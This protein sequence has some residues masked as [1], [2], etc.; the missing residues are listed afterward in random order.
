MIRTRTLI[1]S[2]LVLA[3][4]VALGAGC[5]P[6]PPG[7]TTPPDSGNAA[8][9]G[10]G[11]GGDGGAATGNGGGDGGDGGG[12]GGA[13]GGDGG[14]S[15]DLLAKAIA[16]ECP[17]EVDEEAPTSVFNDAVLI[18]L[19]KGVETFVEETP[20]FAYANPKNAPSV[21]CVEGVPEATITDGRMGYFEDDKK[22][23]AKE[24]A[25]EVMEQLGY[26]EA[27]ILEESGGG[28]GDRRNYT[29][30]LDAPEE[31]GV[32]PATAMLH[33]KS[34]HGRMHY[35]LWAAHPDAWNALKAT[36]KKSAE[37]MLLLNP[38]G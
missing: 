5:K 10:G 23:P 24:S 37:G 35:I 8:G 36:F 32:P 2:S 21:T 16:T 33:L 9:D 15:G 22:K 14:G 34:A 30:I 18:R 25:R 38:E 12:N 6:E 29:M 7:G 3:L 28:S 20:F 1:S 17:A 4:S 13:A 27:K 11:S 26:K 31:E 19:P